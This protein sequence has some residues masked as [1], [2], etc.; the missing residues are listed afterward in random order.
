MEPLSIVVELGLEAIN[1]FY[2]AVERSGSIESWA[3]KVV[4]VGAVCAGKSSLVESL[5]ARQPRLARRADRTR[6]VDV[7]VKTPFK[8]DA[9]SPVQLVFWDF[10]GHNEYYSTHS[11]FLSE[12]ALF[13]L[14][15]DL[16]GFTKNVSSRSDAIHIWLDT[17]LCRTPGAVVQVVAT[18]IDKLSGSLKDA[19]QNLKQAIADHLLAKCAE[20]KSG[21]KK[22]QRKAEMKAPPVLRI[23]DEILTVS[24]KEGTNLPELGKALATLTMDGKM[25]RLSAPP[26]GA[27]EEAGW[28]EGDLFRDLGQKIP[29]IWARACAVMSALRDGIDPGEAARLEQPSPVVNKPLQQISLNDAETT[30]KKVVRASGVSGEI[31]DGGPNRVLKVNT[32]TLES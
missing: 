6:G 7:H 29:V 15:V 13:L 11:L 5:M 24:Y 16:A 3:L 28:G 22:S 12:G 10:A 20:H 2:L 17:L 14:V 23:V 27:F 4:V 8:P 32:Q 9:S 21:W 19:K 18:H 1:Q 26:Q 31:G 25:D 30:W